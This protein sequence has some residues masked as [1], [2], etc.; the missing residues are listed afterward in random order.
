MALSRIEDHTDGVAS[1]SEKSSDLRSLLTVGGISAA[2][3]GV[4]LVALFGPP[5]SDLSIALTIVTAVG[6]AAAIG[7]GF[8]LASI[9]SRR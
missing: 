6:A 7:A 5:G 2:G 8:V 3:L 4:S 1:A 9:A